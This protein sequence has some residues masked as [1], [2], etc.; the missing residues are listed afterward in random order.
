MRCSLANFHKQCHQHF[1]N[2]FQ[3]I[4]F[5]FSLYFPFF[6]HEIESILRLS[7]AQWHYIMFLAGN[8]LM[9]CVDLSRK[10]WPQ[11]KFAYVHLF[12]NINERHRNTTKY[13]YNNDV[14]EKWYILLAFHQCD[15]HNKI[16]SHRNGRA[17]FKFIF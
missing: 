10:I 5:I 16:G 2:C 3:F 13:I 14:H 6:S 11:T 12:H 7:I 4:N 1:T 15:L 8:H 17:A 9:K